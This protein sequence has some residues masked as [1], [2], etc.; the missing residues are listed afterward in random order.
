MTVADFIS[1]SPLS[2]CNDIDLPCFT[3]WHPYLAALCRSRDHLGQTRTTT[4]GKLEALRRCHLLHASLSTPSTMIGENTPRASSWTTTTVDQ[5]TRFSLLRDAATVG[6]A[7]D[8]GSPSVSRPE[9]IGRRCVFFGKLAKR[10]WWV[11][12]EPV[13]VCTTASAS[14]G[15][16][17]SWP[18]SDLSIVLRTLSGYYPLSACHSA[19]P[20]RT[21]GCYCMSSAAP[22]SGRLGLRCDARKFWSKRHSLGDD[23]RLSFSEVPQ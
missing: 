21:T 6:V 15:T 13:N 20:K 9:Q 7:V 5:P 10:E 18:S 8:G 3:W 17:R 4:A 14:P 16:Y 2:L 22:F 23:A 19:P 1:I 12:Q 11:A